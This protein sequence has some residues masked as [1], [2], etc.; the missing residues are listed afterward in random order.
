MNNFPLPYRD[1]SFLKHYMFPTQGFR[2]T[3]ILTA[4]GC[5]MKCA[6]CEHAG[7]DVKLYRPE[8]VGRQID[9]AQAAGFDAIMFFD[10]IFCLSRH[11]VLELSREIVKR[12]IR[13][14]CFGHAR[15][16][17]REI[18]DILASTGCIEVGFGAESGSQSILDAVNKKTT[19][20]QNMA[21]VEMCNEHRI[22]VKAFLMLGL[23]GETPETIAET[24][25]FLDF[26]TSR[27]F[28]N[29]AGQT[30]TNDF[31]LGIYFPY[32]GTA[33]REA[34]ER[35][36]AAYDLSLAHDPDRYRGV[37]KGRDG[38]AEATV[39]TGALSSEEIASWRNRL[40]R[41]YKAKVVG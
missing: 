23:P 10:D 25:A 15:T 1:P 13:Y 11:R 41:L 24:A 14:R 22:K 31:D 5:P 12:R 19:V 28:L 7:T 36:S 33:I 38:E 26:L 4:K 9:Q 21:L 3:T 37:Y 17:T 30:A 34:I 27:T 18:A 32:K 39:R 29:Q 6:F 40:Y 8:I 2:A 16:M 20:R 35:S